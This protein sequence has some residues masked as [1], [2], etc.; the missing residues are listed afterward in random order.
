MPYFEYYIMPVYS[1]GDGSARAISAAIGRRFAYPT[2]ALR[3][4]VQGR[5]V[6]T[7]YVNTKGRVE[8][9]KVIEG[10]WPS[11]NTE[12]GLPHQNSGITQQLG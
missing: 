2:D 12:A 3:A 9:I 11:I 8:D 1:E 7:F 4:G 10:L 5:V 6:L